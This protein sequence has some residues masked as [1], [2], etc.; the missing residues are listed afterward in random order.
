MCGVCS[1]ACTDDL[2]CAGVNEAARCVQ[3][4]TTRYASSCESAAPERLC[5][6][7]ADVSAPGGRPSPSADAGPPRD[8]GPRP[9]EVPT[10]ED[11]EPA[12]CVDTASGCLKCDSAWQSLENDAQDLVE[13]A[14][15][16]D[17][18]GQCFGSD[19]AP[20]GCIDD[21]LSCPP[22][23]RVAVNDSGGCYLFGDCLPFGFGAPNGIEREQHA[24]SDAIG[25]TRSN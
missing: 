19:P 7:S 13:S 1:S 21:D 2:S 6:R 11:P 10:E 12:S 25:I 24:C 4:D 20:V 14:F 18:V 22:A 15:P 17:P 8:D 5:V 9:A 3:R 16:Y 23:T